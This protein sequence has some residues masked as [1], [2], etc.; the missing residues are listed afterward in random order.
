MKR[1]RFSLEVR[2]G[3]V[4]LLAGLYFLLLVCASGAD[5]NGA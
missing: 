2:P 1:R 3:A 5:R 4:V